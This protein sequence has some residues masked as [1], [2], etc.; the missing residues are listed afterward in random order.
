ME[1]EF[2][3]GGEVF[4]WNAEKAATNIAKHGVTF[5][6]AA[7]VFFDP[8]FQIT[9]ADRNDEARDALIGID[10]RLRLLYVV[11]IDNDADGHIRIISARP[12]TTQERKLYGD[13]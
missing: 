13:I 11:H 4:R 6:Q 9:N 1:I 7:Q 8:N 5:E 2:E 12:A 10:A 3:L